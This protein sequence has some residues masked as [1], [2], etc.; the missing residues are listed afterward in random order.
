MP[1]AIR[2]LADWRCR[3]LLASLLW[4][5]VMA[6][7]GLHHVLEASL[8]PA[9][10]R[11]EVVDTISRSDGG[12]IRVLEFSLHSGLT[13]A[14][15]EPGVRLQEIA[16]DTEGQP[17]E[18]NR[19][20]GTGPV[21]VRYRLE[22]P[23][24]RASVSLRYQGR[25]RHA[26]RRQDEEYARGFQETPGT[27]SPT[28]VFLAGYSFWYPQVA[29]EP[30]TFE[31]ALQL[32]PGWSGMTQ[33]ERT[34][35]VA[36]PNVGVEEHWRCDRPQ[37]EIYLLAGRFSEYRQT[38]NGVLAMVLLRKPDPS[39]AQRYLDATAEYIGLYADLIGPYPYTKFALVENFWETGYG[40]PSFTLLGPKV[41]RFPFILH[42]SYPHE[43]L[44]NWWGNG[45]YVDYARGNWAEGLTS[46][47]AD[48]LIKEQR[49]QAADYRRSV[50]RKYTDYVRRQDDFALT[51]FRARH[52]AASEA[53]GY[54]KTLMLF[55]ML[56]RDLGDTV[57][58][59]GLREL[60]R[61]YRFRVADFKAVEAV[62]SATA[63]QP[64]EAFF[65]QWVQRPGAPELRIR[66][67]AAAP[68]GNG[69]RL[70][71]EIEQAQPG[72]PYDL[73]VP[74]A[75]QLEGITP[76]RELEVRLAQKNTVLQLDLPARPLQLAVDPRFDVFRRLHREEI[77]PAISQA[78]GA[79][80]TLIV[81]PDAA[82]AEFRRAYEDLAR[83]WQADRP[84]SVAV[85]SDT[86]LERLPAD[87]A[88]WLFGRE[89]RFR[90]RLA[91]ALPS[92][93]Y[94]ERDGAVRIAG[95]A[96][97][98][99]RHVVVIGRHNANPEHALGWLAVADPAALPGLGRRLPHYGKYSYLAFAGTAPE[100]VLKGQWPVRHS[101][102]IR[103][104]AQADG[105]VPAPA[106]APVLPDRA[107]LAAAPV[108]FS[109][110]RMQQDIAVLADPSMAGRGLG[111]AALD[112]A[113]DYIAGQ[114]Q[115]AGLEPGG[116][117]GT[118]WL[119]VWREPVAALERTLTLKNVIGIL[120]GSDPRRAGE[121]LVI[122]A[123]YDH[124][125]Y[126]EVGASAGNR[127]KVHPGADDNASGVAVL[128]E[129][130]R[131]LAGRP[132]P[133]SIVF[134]AFTGE[135]TGRLGSKHFLQHSERYP[136]EGMIA[137]VNLD[138]V[139][140]LGERDLLVLGSGSAAEWAHILRGAGYVTGVPIQPVAADIGASDQASF[141][142]AG[143]PAV[144][145]FSGAH[146][147]YHGPA[148]TPAGIDAAGLVKIARVLG[149]V[150]T[151]LAARPQALH[152]T[153]ARQ[154]SGTAA[155]DGRTRRV[156]LGILPDYSWGGEGVRIEAVRSGTPAAGAG[157]QAGDIITAV[158]ASSVSG[159][160]A[161]A[162]ALQEL[163]PGDAV[164]IAFRRGDVEQEAT[165]RVMIR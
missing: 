52:S 93:D 157:L 151:Y 97:G 76:A 130:A 106:Q 50:L 74:V 147:D 104:V 163:Q 134:V 5:P 36:E 154:E 44:H 47:L 62:F 60:Y 3:W 38:A 4:L 73:S 95:T 135:E 63:G 162:R 45:V 141:I 58:I 46:Y 77:P 108:A 13:P 64:L 138:T 116:D 37:E 100:N 86:G 84:G 1:R 113:A 11:L 15:A 118:A 35:H 96:L 24:D 48:H 124:L 111:T 80:R 148:D 49:G 42:S 7:A 75:V 41:I 66:K 81:L 17:P 14:A 110:E 117:R 143:V 132:Q 71:V 18:G 31:L 10:G 161:Y 39:L 92:Q 152:T 53:V 156:R 21:P 69:Y 146:P 145:L 78:L 153:P 123:H 103:P 19:P 83:S 20:R 101:P 149:E 67:A 12:A 28:G 79:K 105:S 129:L 99:D 127:G 102:L 89:N 23:D 2:S 126:G 131:V 122:G 25:I 65:R 29:G 40:M 26:L 120:P 94:A 16:G 72:D 114:L 55:H 155:A 165:T 144:Q 125:G 33:G 70:T 32:P 27:I 91:A 150:T 119:Q 112:R 121:S 56:R 51:A 90:S 133:R 6:S 139:G 57:F 43:I 82:P 115:A 87:R 158:N 8:S 54:G 88:V 142:E 140:R 137:M 160:R 22:L 164:R 109:R 9:E 30:V 98:P 136:P 107:P 34:A 68:A 59:Q 128:L 159:L 85:V 61:Q